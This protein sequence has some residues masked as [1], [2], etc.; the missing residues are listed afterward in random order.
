MTEVEEPLRA[1]NCP[2]LEC[3]CAEDGGN[4]NMVLT[5]N[6]G[7]PAVYGKKIS[8][9]LTKTKMATDGEREEYCGSSY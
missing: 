4:L 2:I 9:I 3:T 8:G 5:I 6:K 1:S 7:P